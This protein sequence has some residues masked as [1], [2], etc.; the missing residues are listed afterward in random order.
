MHTAGGVSHSVAVWLSQDM[1]PEMPSIITDA[2]GNLAASCSPDTGASWGGVSK[3]C[4]SAIQPAGI[5]V[6]WLHVCIQSFISAKSTSVCLRCLL[7]GYVWAQE[8]GLVLPQGAQL[9][10]RTGPHTL[11]HDGYALIG[12][13]TRLHAE[14]LIQWA[15]HGPVPMSTKVPGWRTPLWN[16][17]EVSVTV[18]HLLC[19]AWPLKW[20]SR[21]VYL[22][23][24]SNNSVKMLLIFGADSITDWHLGCYVL[25]PGLKP[26]LCVLFRT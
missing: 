2:C 21:T 12:G 3:G 9:Y 10:Q 16:S 11:C 1:V 25:G 6:M 22:L 5:P 7:P 4:C 18:W 14:V 19:Q 17:P 13:D 24:D 8:Q 15:L 20:T 23:V 26:C